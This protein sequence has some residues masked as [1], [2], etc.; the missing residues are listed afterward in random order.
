[1]VDLREARDLAESGKL[2]DAMRMVT[3]ALQEDVND[4]K[5]LVLASFIC[6]KSGQ[7]GIAYHIAKRVTDLYPNEGSGWTNLGRCADSLWRMEEAE[8]AYK[9]A[10]K[11]ETRGHKRLTVLVNMAA[12]YLQVGRFEEARPYAEEALKIDPEHLKARHNLGICQLAAKEWGDAWTNYA[13]SLGSAHR[14]LV[15]YNDEPEWKG[16]PGTVVIYGEQGIGDEI[17]SAS[18][19]PDAIDRA[20]KV[21]I[22]CDSRLV[23][24]YRRSFPTAR[25][26]GTRTAKVL[27]WAEEDRKIDFSISSMQLG[28]LFRTK[29]ADFAGKPY[30]KADP[31][32]T[33][34][35]EALFK[36]KGKPVIGVS[37][38]GGVRNTGAKFRQWKLDD[39]LPLFRSVNAHWVSLQYKDAQPE[40][41]E[42]RKKHPEV[43]LV[44]YP[45]ATLTRDYDDTA[46]IVNACDMVI[47][48]Q[49]AVLHLAG[50]LGKRAW[51]FVPKT[52]QWRYA[53]EEDYTPWYQSVRVWR[54]KNKAEW[55]SVLHAAA[56][57]LKASFKYRGQVGVAYSEAA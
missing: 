25:V 57:E 41:D 46:A 54:Q 50:G 22:D 53:G 33:L 45:H 5:A 56:Q 35:W 32:R 7:D 51:A 8:R 14:N 2:A 23:G 11:C 37:W 44:Q 29:A 20:S 12:L 16:E 19:F 28:G 39:L 49:T 15:K 40:I 21:I 42:F 13:A 38:T 31:D 47:A 17:N 55:R 18:M 24:L 10:L 4:P 43:D 26:Y 27:N 36:T 9:R 34:M 3:E 30:L 6:E 52:S 48:M 1:M